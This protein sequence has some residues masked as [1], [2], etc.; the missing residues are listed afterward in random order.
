MLAA[1]LLLAYKL[2]SVQRHVP[3]LWL[4]GKCTDLSETTIAAAERDVCR[5][6]DWRLMPIVDDRFCDGGD[7]FCDRGGERLS[8]DAGPRKRQRVA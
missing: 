6:A 8:A 2:V 3:P 4:L 1:C 5:A 7:R